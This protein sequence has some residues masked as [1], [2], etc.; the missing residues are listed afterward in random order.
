MSRPLCDRK[1]VTLLRQVRDRGQRSSELRA[2]DLA[3]LYQLRNDAFGHVDGN[4]KADA[5]AAALLAAGR[6]D[7]RID[8]D[9]SAELI[10]QRTARVAGIDRGVGL[11]CG[12]DRMA[13]LSA[14]RTLETGDHTRRERAVQTER[15]PDR[16]DFLRR[17]PACPNRP[18]AQPGSPAGG[19]AILITARSVS[20]SP[21][22]TV[23]V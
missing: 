13:I 16:Q 10:E 7:L 15:I 11:N 6:Q 14:D 18:A 4:G 17:R 8:A 20:G 19:E 23:A 21:P 5:D 1:F 12:V 3:E 22:T 9:H 2:L